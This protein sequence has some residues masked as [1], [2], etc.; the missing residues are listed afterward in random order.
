MSDRTN[1]ILFI[2]PYVPSIRLRERESVIKQKHFHHITPSLVPLS[3]YLPAA[4]SFTLV[5]RLSWSA[6]SP[7]H[8]RLTHYPC[9]YGL[10][11]P[12]CSGLT[13]LRPPFTPPGGSVLGALLSEPC[14][15]DGE[16]AVGA[17]C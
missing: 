9:L 11:G 17:A 13:A 2:L 1:R 5:L 12:L 15:Q 10:P 6:P 8:H 4:H 7:L 3:L 16:P 14:N